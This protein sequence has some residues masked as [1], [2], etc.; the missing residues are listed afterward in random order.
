[1]SWRAPP[2]PPP[3][4][5]NGGD[6]ERPDQIRMRVSV[7]HSHSITLQPP[8]INRL[9]P[10]SDILFLSKRPD[11]A[12]IT[13]SRTANLYSDGSHAR[14]N[15]QNITY[16]KQIMIETE[17]HTHRERERE[18]ERQMVRRCSNLMKSNISIKRLHSN[19]PNDELDNGPSCAVIG[20]HGLLCAIDTRRHL[21]HNGISSAADSHICRQ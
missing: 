6:E 3:G 16:A 2:T 13:P 5:R 18:G 1:M 4:K 8:S 21:L 20:Q 14:M 10:S 19:T 9:L 15:H 7:A 17:T 12:L 11:N